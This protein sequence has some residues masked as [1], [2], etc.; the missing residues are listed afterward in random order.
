[1]RKIGL[2]CL[3]LVLG[4]KIWPQQYFPVKQDKKWGLIDAEGQIVLAPRYEAIGEFKAFGYAVMQRD[5]GVGL[6]DK[7][8]K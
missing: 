1:M 2:L 8:G 3:L 7:S 5:G 6:L 4:G